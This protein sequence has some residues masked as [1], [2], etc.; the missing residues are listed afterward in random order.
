MLPACP[1]WTCLVSKRRALAA[2]RATRSQRH[3]ARVS[4]L[5]TVARP[6][7]RRRGR[8]RGP[9][10]PLKV[11]ELQEIADLAATGEALGL[12]VRRIPPFAGTENLHLPWLPARDRGGHGPCR[13]RPEGLS[14]PAPALAHVL[15]DDAGTAAARELTRSPHYQTHCA[16]G[17]SPTALQPTRH[18]SP[19]ALQPDRTSARP[20]QKAPSITCTLP[21]RTLATSKRTGPLA[22]GSPRSNE[23]GPQTIGRPDA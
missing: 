6:A 20:T 11:E 3:V 16:T 17:L 10:A 7:P 13:G 22:A 19:T 4:S 18:L 5:S 9:I 1:S 14:G 23:L 21:V 2:G 8:R 15:L 12:D